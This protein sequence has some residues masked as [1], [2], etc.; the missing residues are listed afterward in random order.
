MKPQASARPVDN[1][2]GRLVL[3]GRE[4]SGSLAEHGWNNTH[5]PGK[6]PELPEVEA[7]C[8]RIAP[9]VAGRTVRAVHILRPLVARPQRAARLVETARGR[10]ILAVRRRGNNILID[11]SGGFTLRIHLRMTGELGVDLPI[12][13]STRLW[14]QLSG[15]RTLVFDDARALGRVH[16]HSR[17]A[18]EKALAGLGPEPLSKTFTLASFIETARRSR[19][20]AKLFLMDQRRVAGLGNIYAAEALFRA[21]VNPRQPMHRVGETKLAALYAAIRQ[22][23]RDA[24]KSARIAYNHPGKTTEA[25]RFARAVY[26]RGGEPCFACGTGIRRIEQG[27]RSTYY[28]PD[29]QR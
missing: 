5:Y 4:T 23:L 2:P 25:E 15:S 1:M 27:G 3:S 13:P 10:K 17:A 7:V 22:T 16:M 26:G 18:L 6:V 20:P 8:R 21:R 19:Q 29:C 28:C 12:T 24:L 9:H 11:L 14:L